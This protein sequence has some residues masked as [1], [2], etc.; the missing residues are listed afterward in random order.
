MQAIRTREA[1][2]A[3]KRAEQTHLAKIERAKLDA[4]QAEQWRNGTCNGYLHNQPVMLRIRTFNAHESVQFLVAQ[5]ETSRGA[6]PLY[7][8]PCVVFVSCGDHLA[9]SK[10]TWVDCLQG[11]VITP[12]I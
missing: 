11:V 5:V 8:M 12:E 7:L 6:V 1:K 4:E 3:A 10:L 9:C 2:N